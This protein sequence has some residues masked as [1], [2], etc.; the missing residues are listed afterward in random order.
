MQGLRDIA[1]GA[2]SALETQ[3][4]GLGRNP[5]PGFSTGTGCP[6][7]A[8]AARG[9]LWGPSLP[10][11][12]VRPPGGEA[13]VPLLPG[14]RKKLQRP[15]KHARNLNTPWGWQDAPRGFR[16]QGTPDCPFL[17]ASGAPLLVTSEAKA[18]I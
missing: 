5:T 16:P 3:V 6:E 18:S 15:V 8:G 13:Q 12:H 9:C 17:D 4:W 14:H 7:H 1:R 2:K 10:H 11:S